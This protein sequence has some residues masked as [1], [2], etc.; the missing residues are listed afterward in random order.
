MIL[1]LIVPVYNTEAYL[2]DCLQSLLAQD[3]SLEEYEIICVN[4]GSTDGSMEILRRYEKEYPNVIVV[5]QPNGGVCRARNAGLQEAKGAFIWYV[6][7]DDFLQENCL[8]ELAAILKEGHLDRLV[9]GNYLYLDGGDNREMKQNTSWEDSVVWRN[10]FR[11]EFLMERNLLFHYPEL[12]FGEDALYMYEV[13]RQC[14]KT[15]VMDM[16]VYFHRERPGSLSTAISPATE[17]KRLLCNIR[18]AE[19]MKGYCNP[20]GSLEKGAA[21]RFMAFW[22]GALYRIS[23]MPRKEAAI[24][25]KMLKEA[26][27]YPC[28]KPSGSTTDHCP[29]INRK[30]AIGKIIDIL[31]VNLGTRWGYW[32]MRTVHGAFRMKSRIFKEM[33]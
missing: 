5:D 16:P 10:L 25:L 23:Q 18:E 22:L 27:L 13:T 12:S 31:Y 11:R 7:S 32:G 29:E 6:D 8:G 17:K 19:I 33:Q 2:D 20:D 26:G 15:G 21:N 1:S 4:D 14:P 24:Y 3:I 9:I 28:K 30:D